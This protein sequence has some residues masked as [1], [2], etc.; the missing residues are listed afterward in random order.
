MVMLEQ[1]R[2]IYVELRTRL[3]N[4]CIEIFSLEKIMSLGQENWKGYGKIINVCSVQTKN[5]FEQFFHDLGMKNNSIF[6]P[7]EKFVI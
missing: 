5:I 4:T 3:D 2:V 7:V 1:K 6:V